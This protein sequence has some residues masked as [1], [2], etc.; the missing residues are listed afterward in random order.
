MKIA[1]FVNQFP[2]LSETFIL[3]QITG[4]IDRGHEI[5]IYADHPG[6]MSKIHPEV[7]KYNLLANTHY[8][9]KPDNRILRLIKIFK[10]LPN[11]GQYP[12]LLLHSINFLKYGRQATSLTLFYTVAQLLNKPK[13]YD[14]VH[15]HFGTNGLKAILLRELNVIQGKLVTAFHG[16]DVSQYI[17]KHGNNAYAKLFATGELCCPISRHM[18]LRLADLGCNENQ[19]VIH[20]MG[21]DCSKFLFTLRQQPQDGIVQIITIARLVEKKGVE[22]GIRAV[23]NL[24]KSGMKIEYNIVGD[25][26]LRENLQQLIQELDLI[27]SVKLLG[28]K[29]QQEVVKIL[30]NSHILLAPSV[31][32]QEGD[33]EGIPIVLIEAIA[34]GLPVV[35]TY[36]S[37]IPELI[38]NG[39]SGFLVPERDVNALTEKLH[40]LVEHPESW[41][42][43]GLAGRVFVE[44]NYDI[45]KLNDKLVEIYKNI[46][47][48][49]TEQKTALTTSASI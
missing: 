12:I 36:H 27:D 9:G 30:D 4:L 38:E 22:Y 11:F 33:Q 25:G 49:D 44:E 5:Y 10:L 26:F 23:A 29:Q 19:L 7:E 37:G 14:I 42:S 34:M 39:K 46:S 31:T 1:F 13:V 48:Q 32:S 8:I 21:I 24:I 45:N 47:Y 6:D 3:N 15:C 16:Y 40:Y 2:T 41:A 43:I 35:S 17:K 20:R 18:K 28:W